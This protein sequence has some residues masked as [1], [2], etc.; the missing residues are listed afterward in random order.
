MVPVLSAS[1]RLEPA[2]LDQANVG[3]RVEKQ[4]EVIS[5]EVRGLVGI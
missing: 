1:R 4:A 3:E 2:D 5:S